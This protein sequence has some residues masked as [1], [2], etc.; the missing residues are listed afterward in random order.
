MID[1]E[2]RYGR[3]RVL[4]L[5][6]VVGASA[7]AGCTESGDGTDDDGSSGDDDDGTAPAGGDGDGGSDDGDSGTGGNGDDSDSG[8][9]GGGSN[10]EDSDGSNG[11]DGEGEEDDGE[12]GGGEED[13]E[14]GDGNDDGSDDSGDGPRLRDVFAFEQ[15]YV[16]EFDSTDGSGTWTFH[17]GDTYFEGT[18]EGEQTEIYRIETGSGVDTYTVAGGQC[19]KTSVDLEQG[20]VFDPE[21]PEADSEEYYANGTETVDGQEAYVFDVEGGTYYVSVATGYPV[22]FESQEGDVVTFRSWGET[23][24]I[25]PPEGECTEL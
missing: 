12:D 5:A 20:D 23:D 15:S 24:P 18:F 14:N 4:Y 7:L 25:T 13:D 1:R 8:E 6:G 19:F 3:R 11:E 9:E 2:S 21:Q 16:M 22:R 10:G 17:E